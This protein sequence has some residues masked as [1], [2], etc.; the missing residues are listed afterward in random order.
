MSEMSEMFNFVITEDQSVEEKIQRTAEKLKEK[1]TTKRKVNEKKLLKPVPIWKKVISVVTDV[2]LI[3]LCVL[4]CLFGVTSF[5]FKGKDLPPTFA[6][7]SFMRVQTGSM[8][9]AGFDPG[10]AIV[11]RRVDTKTLNVGDYIAFYVYGKEYNKFLDLESELIDKEVTKHRYPLDAKSFFGIPNDSIQSAANVGSSIV[12]HEI[13]RIYEDE[14]GMLWFKTQGKSEESEDHWTIGENMVVGLYDGSVVAKGFS[15]L[16]QALTS[17][18]AMVY[19]VGVPLVLIS[20]SFVLKCLKNV[21]LAKLELDCIEEKRKITDEICVK[22]NIG[23]NMS[24]QNKYKILAQATP[25]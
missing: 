9:A 1:Y 7:Y 14:N 8:R 12:F 11:V 3:L 21:Q 10:D 19:I 25:E 23:F 5:Y 2:L 18:R 17:S 6:G 16:L 15:V 13:I 20:I 4:C 24:N 22:N